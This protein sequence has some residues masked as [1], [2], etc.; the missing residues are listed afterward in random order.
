MAAECLV[1]LSG[2]AVGH[3]YLTVTGTAADE[4]TAPVGRVLDET[5][6]PDSAIVHGQL[7]LLALQIRRVRVEPHQ[8][9]RLVVAAGSDQRSIR[10]PRHAVYR[11]LVVSGT[12]EQHGRLLG[13][14]IL[15][16]TTKI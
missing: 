16:E 9:Y 3:V 10:R 11:A 12:F 2:L 14:M 8:L 5:N 4:Q 15:S 7:D 6:V 1:R 13:H